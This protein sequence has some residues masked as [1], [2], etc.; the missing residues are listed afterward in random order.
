MLVALTNAVSPRLVE[1]YGSVDYL[2]AQRQHEEY[3]Q[4]LERH[5]VKV[6][7][8][9][10]NASYPN[11]CFIEDTAIVVD[12]IAIITSMGVENRRGEPSAIKKVLARYR[13]VARVSSPATIE[14]GD[15]LRIGRKVFVGTSSRTNSQGVEAVARILSPFGFDVRAVGV[16]GGLH[17]KSACTALDDETLLVNQEWVDVDALNGFRRLP[18]SEDEMMAA[19]TLRIGENIILQAG[20]PKTIEMVQ[21]RFEHTEVLDISEFVKAEAGLTCLSLVFEHSH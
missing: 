12:E 11:G 18:V 10:E 5:G 7:R 16:R 13:Q 19:N 17:L 4:A 1:R 14:G 3:C 8:L 15:V 2:L 20:F 21:E 6:E 9:A